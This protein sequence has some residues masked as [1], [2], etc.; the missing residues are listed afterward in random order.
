MKMVRL[1]LFGAPGSG[2]GTQADSIEDKYGYKKIST[3]DLVRAEV[4]A[5]TELGVEI[6]S[7]TERGELVP[8]ET[9]IEILKKRLKQEDIKNGYIMDGFPR[10][11]HQAEALSLMEVD[12]EVAIYLNIVDE[13]VIIKRLLSRLT[14]TNPACGAIFNLENNPPEKAG[15]C[16]FCGSPIKQ[17]A[18]DNEETVRK[19]IEVYREQT[20]P[21]IDYYKHKGKLHEIDASRTIKKVFESIVGV[22]N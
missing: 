4:S 12:G 3:G 20:Q 1:I 13:D 16:D 2:K 21:V 9:I 19:R 8:D 7:I 10:T 17:R 6:K 15:R 11:R 22:L 5:K 18:D 14:C